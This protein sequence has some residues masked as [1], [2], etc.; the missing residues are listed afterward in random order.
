MIVN[1]NQP[2]TD[3]SENLYSISDE[4]AA[5]ANSASKRARDTFEVLKPEEA[6]L[7]Q[8][9][10]IMSNAYVVPFTISFIV[11]CILEYYFS[12]E[13]YRDILPQAPWVIGIGIIFISIVIA[14][15][16]VG[17]LS[18]HTR[19]RRFFEDK[20]ILANASTPD[21]DIIRGVYKHARGQFIF[22]SILFIAIGGAIFYFSKERVAREIAAGIR[23]SAFGIQDIL[24]VL[25]Y[26]LEVLAGLFVF[27]LFKRSVVA[28]KNYSNRKKYSKEVEI[29]RQHTSESCKYFDNA[30][31][32]GYNTFLDDVSNNLH[33]GFYRNKHQNTNQQHLNYVN[34]PEIEQQFFK[35]KFLNVN[36]QAVQV[37]IDVLT[38]YKFKESKTSDASGLIEL[39]INSYPQ[40][41]IKQ[42]RITYFNSNDDKVVEEISGNYSLNND[43]PYE[44][45]LK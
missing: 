2:S 32:K 24:P 16:L 37:T 15:L 28:Y 25:F 26:V 35:A 4:V 17:M 3:E 31:K 43:V 8:W 19:N 1:W 12:R 21:S 34:E 20:K 7:N 13:I 30:E 23:E 27:Y 41:Q 5:R 10:K 9:D 38:E 11:I 29:A 42:F 18:A 40:D 6:K 33:L 14:E 45:I 22:G 36:G 44:I 39:T